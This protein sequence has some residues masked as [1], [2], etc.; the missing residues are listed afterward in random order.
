V[1]RCKKGDSA[2]LGVISE[3][4]GGFLINSRAASADAPLT[5]QPLVLA[6]RV[7]V[8]VSTENGPIAIGDWLAPASAPG[9]AMRASEPG[10]VVGIA[11]E[12]FDGRAKKSGTVL[13]F[14]KVGEGNSAK[15]VARLERENAELRERLA[16]LESAVEILTQ[17][18]RAG[19]RDKLALRR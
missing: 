14:L 13:C 5:G 7:P 10:A 6:G 8:K 18:A 4:T 1:V 9:V 11:L 15:L 19:S 17:N 12:A 16:R 3:G 2:V